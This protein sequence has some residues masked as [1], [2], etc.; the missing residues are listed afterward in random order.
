MSRQSKKSNV[1][2]KA[3]SRFKILKSR[4]NRRRAILLSVVALICVSLFTF[5]LITPTGIIEYFQNNYA[6]SQDL[7][8]SYM[9][10]P[11]STVEQFSSNNNAA[12]LLSSTYFE[13]FN[14]RGNN[15]L[16][17]KHGFSSPV[18]ETSP[19]RVLVY[20]R[21]GKK[22][23]V[24]NYST[25]IYERTLKNNIYSADISRDGKCA[26]V[27]DSNSH[28]SELFVYDDDQ[29]LIYNWKCS[30][31]LL[32]SVSFNES[33][34]KV[35]TAE[36][37]TEGG[38]LSS[39][40]NLFNMSDE[41]PSNTIL[42]DGE[43]IT[44]LFNCSGKLIAASESNV[45]IMNWKNGEYTTISTDGIISFLSSDID[46]QLMIVFSRED[47][48][49]YN[50]ICLYNNDFEKVASFTVNAV[51]ADVISDEKGVY[52]VYDNKLCKYDLQGNLTDTVTSIYNI[53]RITFIDNGNSFAAC[54]TSKI[55]VF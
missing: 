31:N 16:Y 51:L 43:I 29:E 50:N 21:G 32:S 8:D 20:D 28:S 46:D 6:V 33:G 22:F 19:A 39:K 3:R 34:T 53:Q 12:F 13:I 11:N 23:K 55:I 47:K 15:V 9:V 37:F 48:Q 25:V 54:G 27:T 35:A 44:S 49:T 42:F 40:V 41:S 10:D 18:M 36:I 30:G 4:K 17:F 5:Y 14:K 45:Y 2:D 52:A 38:I 7:G 24:F 1:T 26:F